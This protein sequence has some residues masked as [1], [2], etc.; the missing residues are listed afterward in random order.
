MAGFAYPYNP[1]ANNDACVVL[2]E[3]HNMF[4]VTNAWRCIIP[5][6]APFFHG[7]VILEHVD[8]NGIAHELHEGLDFYYGH[9]SEEI[10]KL[11]RQRVYGSVMLI[12]PLTGSVRFKTYETVGGAFNVRRKDALEYL[13]KKDMPDPRNEDWS[14]VMKYHRVVD[15]SDRPVNLPEAIQKDVVTKSLK[16]LVDKL[17]ELNTT[18][19]QQFAAIFNRIHALGT[20]IG[21]YDLRGHQ[22]QHDAHKLTYQK[23]NALGKDETAVNALRAYGRT[24]AELILLIK[25][26]G[27]QQENVDQYYELLGGTFQGRISFADGATCLIQNVAGTSIIDFNGGNIKILADRSVTLSADTDKNSVDV[28]MINTAGNNVLS[29]HSSGTGTDENAAKFNGYYLIHVGNIDQYLAIVGETT[30]AKFD[31]NVANTATAN[32]SGKGTEADP[33]TGYVTFPTATSSTAGMVRL[34]PSLYT[35]DAGYVATAKAL[36]ELT[37][38][39]DSY[40]SNTRKVQGKALTADLTFNKSDIGLSLVNNTAA[41]NKPASTAFKDA[42][43]GKAVVGHKHDLSDSGMLDPA[44]SDVRGIVK[45]TSTMNPSD[46]SNAV[47]Q[48][49]GTLMHNSVE[50]QSGLG[51]GKLLSSVVHVIEYG[52]RSQQPLFSLSGNVLTVRGAVRYFTMSLSNIME[53]WVCDLATAYPPAL[54]G[55]EAHVYLDYVNDAL[56]YTV[57]PRRADTDTGSW[58]GYVVLQPTVKIVQ[59]PFVRLLHVV[60]LEEHI[61]SNSAHNFNTNIRRLLGLP[62][63]ENKPIVNEVVMP[64]FQQVF[65]SWYRI[66]HGGSNR[67]P[68]TPEETLTWAYDEATASIRNTTN[69]ATFIG[70]VSLNTVGDYDFEVGLSS[71]NG[72]DD[73]VGIILAFY[74][75]PITSKE[76]TLS[77]IRSLGETNTLDSDVQYRYNFGQSDGYSLR[78]AGSR[79]QIGWNVAGETIVRATRVGNL[80]HCTVREFSKLN[81]AQPIVDEYTINLDSDPRLAVF[82]G[83]SRYGY[84]AQSQQDSTWRSI[85]W[86]EGDGRGYYASMKALRDVKEQC[87]DKAII[88]SGVVA[89]GATIPLPAGFSRSDVRTIVIPETFN[90]HAT[91]LKE[92][93]CSADANGVVT[94][95]AVAGD[96]TVVT[97]TVKYY[98]VGVKA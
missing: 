50:A 86:P 83:E 52:T 84:C 7:S 53:A 77:L 81:P 36:L 22:Y 31:I 8:T 3:S 38:R 69:S 4:D 33:L 27:I 24:L 91:F 57:G 19:A 79:K 89:H 80:I 1:E 12:Q 65:N 55:A 23:L 72:D 28:G 60:E 39:L 96:G 62:L 11:T 29:V 46:Q 68:F 10:N 61:R 45:L 82:L 2:N 17:N 67:Y 78:N 6:W 14:D 49:L 30:S 32:L 92:Y 94:H 48:K 95:S 93:R 66:S 63:V 90:G 26:M 44:S 15:P 18:E 64:T 73:S 41:H 9:Y 71:T 13:A 97:G 56:T 74:K 21:N 59:S 87:L 75:D 16:G 70:M 20:K 40:V 98:L 76:Y 47:T 25:Q 88:L 85:R 34:A 42:A 58:L 43:A 51:Q 37:D 35:E 5:L 54:T